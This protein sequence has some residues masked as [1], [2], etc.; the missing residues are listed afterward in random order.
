M[1][2]AIRVPTLASVVTIASDPVDEGGW[3]VPKMKITNLD[4][5]EMYLI[6]AALR[7]ITP[8][9]GGSDAMVCASHVYGQFA[10]QMKKEG[11]Y[12]SE[13]IIERRAQVARYTVVEDYVA[14]TCDGVWPEGLPKLGD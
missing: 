1:A 3:I 13:P 14:N 7:A 9:G 6:V 11:E 10:R 8:M 4:I 5:D 2:T 12:L